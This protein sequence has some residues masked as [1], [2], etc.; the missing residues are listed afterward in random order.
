MDMEVVDG[1]EE[2][3]ASLSGEIDS[4]SCFCPVSVNGDKEG[5]DEEEEEGEVPAF[6]TA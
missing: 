4:E 2:K 1:T 6:D 3:E 5:A